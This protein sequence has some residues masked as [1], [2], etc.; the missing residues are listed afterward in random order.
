M[1][2]WVFRILARSLVSTIVP[3][4]SVTIADLRPL[5][6]FKDKDIPVEFARREAVAREAFNKQLAEDKSR[7][8]KKS[9]GG[10]LSNALGVKGGP[11]G[12]QMMLD[13]QTSLAEGLSQGKMLSDLIRERGQREYE[14]LENEI[15]TNG[16]K[17]LKDMEE[18]EK[19]FMESSMKDMRK[20]WF[21]GFGGN[22]NE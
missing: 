2:P 11:Q 8:P 1:P 7:R 18:E 12:G 16:A 4:V 21:G 6:S 14:R 17:W 3:V 20:S 9:I 5:E 10:L 19:R 22:K 15:R 13:D